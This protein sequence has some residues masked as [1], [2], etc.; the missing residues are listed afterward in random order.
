[1]H[2]TSKPRLLGR[3]HAKAAR[4]DLGAQRGIYIL[5]SPSGEP[6][7]VGQATIIGQRLSHHTWDRLAPRWT[8]FSLFCVLPINSDGSPAGAPADI[9]AK[10]FV[11]ALEGVLIEAM[12]PS[13][14]RQHPLSDVEFL[15]A[16]DPRFPG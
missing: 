8:A 6:I 13:Q 7:Y 4:V 1:M 5:H 16:T 15:Q 2:W 3:E 11:N 12:E 9:S 14:N 10:E